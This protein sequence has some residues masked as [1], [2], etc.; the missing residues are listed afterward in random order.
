MILLKKRLKKIIA[1]ALISKGP[2]LRKKVIPQALEDVG[3][4]SANAG[5][6][7]LWKEK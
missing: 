1:A 4:S 6:G 5:L 7:R 2:L 3:L